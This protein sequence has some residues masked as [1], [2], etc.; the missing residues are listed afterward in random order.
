VP[1]SSVIGRDAGL[2]FG[3]FVVKP[4]VGA[5]SIDAARE[6][7][8][9]RRGAEHV[10]RL[11][12]LGRDVLISL[13]VSVDERASARSYSLPAPQSRHDKGAMLNTPRPSATHCFASNS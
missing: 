7:P 2:S 1:S 11:H 6:T 12:G 5:G 10:Y 8:P 13:R 4:C 3:D 9:T